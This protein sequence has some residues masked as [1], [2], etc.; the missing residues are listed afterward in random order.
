[1]ENECK[2]LI[3]QCSAKTTLVQQMEDREEATQEL[4]AAS[5]ADS[6]IELSRQTEKHAQEI[7]AFQSKVEE[8]K[9]QIH[10]LTNKLEKLES[11]SFVRTCSFIYLFGY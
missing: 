9:T 11:V 1:M 5:I 6:E 8:L 3:S 4:L 7:L 2:A 10:I